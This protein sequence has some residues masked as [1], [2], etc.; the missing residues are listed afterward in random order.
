MN[1][2]KSCYVNKHAKPRALCERFLFRR[3]TET[4]VYK[5]LICFT[6]VLFLQGFVQTDC[7]LVHSSAFMYSWKCKAV[8]TWPLLSPCALLTSAKYGQPSSLRIQSLAVNLKWNNTKGNQWLSDSISCQTL[9]V[10]TCTNSVR[11]SAQNTFRGCSFVPSWIWN[12]N[13]FY[14]NCSWCFST[15]CSCKEMYCVCYSSP[16]GFVVVIKQMSSERETTIT[17]TS[18][19]LKFFIVVQ[20]LTFS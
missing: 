11:R 3:K 2:C 6:L 15:N 9:L 17:R 8:I 4:S 7:P 19:I 18:Q 14:G 10:K 16:C 13:S 12:T 1:S 5:Y 20:S